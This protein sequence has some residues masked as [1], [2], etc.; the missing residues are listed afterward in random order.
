MNR[1]DRLHLLSERETVRQM[2]L[3]MPEANVID[4]CSLEGRLEMLDEQLQGAP[5]DEQEP[6]RARLTFNGRPVV[7]SHGIVADFGMRAVSSFTEAVSTM[8]ASLVSPLAASGPIPNREQYQL[9]ITSTALGSFG[10]ELEEFRSG[11][12][13]LEAS[14]PMAQALESTQNLLRGTLGNDDELADAAS[15]TDPRA[16]D[17]LRSFL[18]VLSDNEAMCHLQLKDQMVRFTS[19][20]Q[21]RTSLRRLSRDNLREE[22]QALE[23]E[24]LGVL[25]LSRTFEF[26]LM[27]NQ[28]G[29]RGK[30]APTVQDIEQINRHIGQSVRI[31][32][33]QTR[34]GHGR[35]RYLLLAMPAWAG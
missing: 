21:I 13:S 1:T 9:L 11:Q 15:E 16:L 28:E 30:V 4:R 5:T 25:P 35:P 8:A 19:V 2:L 12:L 6:A 34:I 7:G 29:I 31:S 14:S 17:K 20:E 3:T 24:F 33:M 10:F 23:G 22:E 32:V 26:R 18:Q 27:Q